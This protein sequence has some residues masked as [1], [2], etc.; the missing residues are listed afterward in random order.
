MAPAF[1]LSLYVD[2]AVSKAES[3]SLNSLLRSR[4][5]SMSTTCGFV[6][7]LVCVHGHEEGRGAA[8]AQREREGGGRETEMGGGGGNRDAKTKGTRRSTM[9]AQTCAATSGLGARSAAGGMRDHAKR[10]VRER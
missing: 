10:A 9:R 4:S 8:A 5:A 1:V 3:T 2:T 6:S 7:V